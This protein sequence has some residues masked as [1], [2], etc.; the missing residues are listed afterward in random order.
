MDSFLCEYSYEEFFVCCFSSFDDLFRA[1]RWRFSGLCSGVLEAQLLL[2]FLKRFI[3]QSIRFGKLSEQVEGRLT[4]AKGYLF[5]C[6]KASEFA[7]A[8]FAEAVELLEEA[9]GPP[10]A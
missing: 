5:G 2:L 10:L 4:E 6:V 9:I 1:R 8:K 3:V 7:A